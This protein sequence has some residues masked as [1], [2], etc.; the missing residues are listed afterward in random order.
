MT[1]PMRRIPRGVLCGVHLVGLTIA[2]ACGSTDR[3]YQG[4]SAGSWSEQL[5]AATPADRIAAADALYHIAPQSSDVV[6]ALLRAMR[7]T[8]GQVQSAVA[9]ALATTGSRSL[10]GLEA[11]L[12]DDHASVR[13]LAIRLL[14]N[15]GARAVGS[16]NAISERLSDTDYIGPQWE[17][18]ARS[19][20]WLDHTRGGR[21]WATTPTPRCA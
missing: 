17:S 18:S 15:Q 1:A 19:T 7:D 5:D 20:R 2:A 14:A 21:S 6:D 10:P 3:A 12:R 16:R 4:R 13:A 8:N 9:V 11:A